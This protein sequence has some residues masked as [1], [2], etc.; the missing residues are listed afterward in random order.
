MNNASCIGG[1]VLDSQQSVR[2][3]KSD[4]FNEPLDTSYKLGDV[5]DLDFKVHRNIEP[6]RVEDVD[7]INRRYVGQQ[8]NLCAFLMNLIQPWRGSP[9]K[10]FNGLI[11]ATDEGK[12]Y[13][14]QVAGV[15][16]MSTGF[17]VPDQ[18]L[19]R[20]IDGSK[21]RYRYPRIHGVRSIPYVGFV[22]SIKT[23]PAGSLVRVS[24]TRWSSRCGY[25]F[26]NGKGRCYLQISGW[27]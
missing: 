8:P 27:Y 10:L 5:W 7:V 1:L 16:N 2:L 13:I 4:G 15:P 17:W 6:P 22:E 19:S 18:P 14:C 12:G 3:L 11:R 20:R 24:L 23:I 26:D 25:L 9:N 21:I